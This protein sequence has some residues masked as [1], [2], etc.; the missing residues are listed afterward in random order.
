MQ[1][2]IE[3]VMGDITK[4][5]CDAIVNAAKSSLTGGGGVDGAIHKAGGSTILDECKLIVA[6][7]GECPTGEAVITSAGKLPAK[8]VI[9]TVGPVW[10][11]GTQSEPEKLANCYRNSLFLAQEHG[12]TSIAF[13]N[14]SAGVYG[15][16]K[17]DAAKIAYHTVKQT[18]SQTPAIKKVVFVCFDEENYQLMLKESGK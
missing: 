2:T 9:H 17:K 4:I 11:G 5:K 13:P 3:I 8:Y 7:S 15:Y 6:Q 1:S 18:L 14:I 16:P 10:E 12:C